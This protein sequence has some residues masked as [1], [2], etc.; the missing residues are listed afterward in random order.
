MELIKVGKVKVAL[1]HIIF[2]Y[3][4]SLKSPLSVIHLKNTYFKNALLLV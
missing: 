2:K 1:F 4:E 3:K